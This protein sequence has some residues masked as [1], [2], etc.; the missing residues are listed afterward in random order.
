MSNVEVRGTITIQ[1][2]TASIG[3]GLVT[4]A[5]YAAEKQPIRADIL[6]PSGGP[7]AIFGVYCLYARSMPMLA[8]T[9]TANGTSV[10]C[11][12]MACRLRDG[13]MLGFGRRGGTSHG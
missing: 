10:A 13:D 5:P 2:V 3:G 4:M 11:A 12:R 8:S 7:A 9:S 1:K 6:A